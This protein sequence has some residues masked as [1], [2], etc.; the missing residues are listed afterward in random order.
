MSECNN[1]YICIWYF[2]PWAILNPAPSIPSITLYAHSQFKHLE[3]LVIP[4][5]LIPQKRSHT[6]NHIIS[7]TLIYQHYHPSTSSSLNIIIHQHHHPSASFITHHPQKHKHLTHL[8]T[9][10]AMAM[11]G[12]SDDG[13]LTFS[14]ALK[15]F[16]PRN[17]LK[18]HSLTNDI[19]FPEFTQWEKQEVAY[20]D[21]QTQRDMWYCIQKYTRM[22]QGAHAAADFITI[23]E[24]DGEFRE[25]RQ[26][27]L[28]NHETRMSKLRWGVIYRMLRKADPWMMKVNI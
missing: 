15:V 27:I 14:E 11:V 10:I 22:I 28:R 2:Y 7:C 21:N 19:I 20:W 12:A 17:W 3:H 16:D 25:A 9:S 4:I 1:V 26:A 13:A 8:W 5:W 18:D 23:N 24:L 6:H